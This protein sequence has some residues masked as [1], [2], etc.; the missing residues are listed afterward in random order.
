LRPGGLYVIEDGITDWTIAT[1]LAPRYPDRQ[2]LRTRFDN[3]RRVYQVINQGGEGIPEDVLEAINETTARGYQA[4]PGATPERILEFIAAAVDTVDLTPAEDLFAAVDL[5]HRPLSD[6][7]IDLV[8]IC[9]T[10]RDVIDEV[11][12]DQHWLMAR[13]GN[14]PLPRDGFSVEDTWPDLFGYLR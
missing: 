14:T 8:M 4:D 11:R 5:D 12:I 13:R 1:A 3:V 10:H 7:A 6:F 9:A 2:M